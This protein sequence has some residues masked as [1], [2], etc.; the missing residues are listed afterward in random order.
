[1]KKKGRNMYI[2]VKVRSEKV[3]EKVKKVLGKVKKKSRKNYSQKNFTR[4][5]SKREKNKF[6]VLSLENRGRE[7]A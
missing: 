4:C 7:G 2:H 6:L 3:L 1:M 5:L